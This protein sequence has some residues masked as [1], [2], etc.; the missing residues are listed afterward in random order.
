[1]NPL[2]ISYKLAAAV[3]NGLAQTQS[4]GAAGNLTLNGSLVTGGVGTLDSGGVA[5]R[6]VITSAADDS[7]L[8]WTITGTDRLGIAQTDTVSGAAVAVKSA[9]DF[10]TVTRIRGSAAT[11]GNVIAGTDGTGSTQWFIREWMSMGALGVL[12]YF[13]P[14]VTATANFE[15]TLDD[16]NVIQDL[17]PYQASPE[18]QSAYPPIAVSPTGWSALNASKIDTVIV[19][20]FAWRMT[21]TAGTD[22]VV[23]QVIETVQA[24]EG[25]GQGGI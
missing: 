1:M 3:S 24:R 21:I 22:P 17:T 18:S 14:G 23:L 12:M 8:T 2:R 20:H 16:P 7:A 5:R 10:K 13:A 15:V 19:P 25:S 4:L 6:V 11:A 9:L